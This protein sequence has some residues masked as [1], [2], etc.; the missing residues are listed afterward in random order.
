MSISFPASPTVG[1][2][3]QGWIWTGTVW[4]PV[5]ASVAPIAV[6]TFTTT[7]TYVPSP[8]LVCA[9]VECV[10]GGAGG[11]SNN[12]VAT[13]TVIFSGGGGSGGYSRKFLTAAQIGASQTITI[14]AGGA[15]ALSNT[16]SGGA[17]GGD[18]SFGS[19][20]IA[21]G[22]PSTGSNWQNPGPGG[23]VAGGV[24]DLV[25]AGSPGGSSS[26]TSNGS[27]IGFGGNSYFGGGGITP[28]TPT[29]GTYSAGVAATGYGSGGS[30]GAQNNAS[31]GPI[32]GNGMAGACVVTEYSS[33]APIQLPQFNA[34]SGSKVLL[35]RQVVS[36][37]QATVNF[38]G[39]ISS[40]YDDYE[41][42]WRNVQVSALAGVAIRCSVDN[43]ATWISTAV[44]AYSSSY[45]LSVGTTVNP[46][47]S[48]GAN[49]LLVSAGIDPPGAS[50]WNGNGVARFFN[51]SNTNPLKFMQ[52]QSVSGQASNGVI[53]ASGAGYVSTSGFSNN[54]VN[55]LEVLLSAAGNITAGTFE[56]FGIQR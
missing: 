46:Q 6:R 53:T 18:T 45:V 22:A 1:Q 11:A 38:T 8:G 2:I 26:N 24:G 42:V 29:S 27:G 28:S 4:N 5:G 32:G 17:A 41:L 14:G 50:V 3:Y 23:P 15:G 9:I 34:T 20:C 49:N 35:S 48:N 16:P 12:I 44:Y 30:G 52:F 54:P 7:Q 40:A 21:K 43:G 37:A 36:A 39:A 10:G 33:A 56:L 25:V 19:L 55:A 47:F 51:P 13:N 31:G